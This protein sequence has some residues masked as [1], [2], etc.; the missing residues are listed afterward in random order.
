MKIAVTGICLA[1][2]HLIQTTPVEKSQPAALAVDE[3]PSCGD[4]TTVTLDS[5]YYGNHRGTLASK[6]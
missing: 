5:Q 3:A 4:T 1:E 6:P 2:S